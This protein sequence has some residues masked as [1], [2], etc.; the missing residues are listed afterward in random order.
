M[1]KKIEPYVTSRYGIQN[2]VGGIWTPHTFE[3]IKEAQD[4]LDAE[5]KRWPSSK[6]KSPL[7]KHKV[8]PVTLTVEARG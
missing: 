3:T 5:R 2:H 4:Y 6:G 1:K 8:I 7:K